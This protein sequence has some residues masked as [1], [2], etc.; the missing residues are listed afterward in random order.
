[1]PL[2]EGKVLLFKFLVHG[3]GKAR[4]KEKRIMKQKRK[5]GF[6]IMSNTKSVISYLNYI[7]IILFFNILVI[8]C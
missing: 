4:E 8:I 3:V 5:K 7:L 2:E 1:M 6:G